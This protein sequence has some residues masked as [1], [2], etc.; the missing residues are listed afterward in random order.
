[1]GRFQRSVRRMWPRVLRRFCPVV[2]RAMSDMVLSA[3]RVQRST[4]EA[5]VAPLGTDSR[6][7]YLSFLGAVGVPVSPTWV[8]A[9]RAA[10]GRFRSDSL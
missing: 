3:E 1:M 9:G 6:S 2:L 5:P 10:D 8:T 7:L 4:R